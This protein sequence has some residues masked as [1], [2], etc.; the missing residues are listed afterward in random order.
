MRKRFTEEQILAVLA[1][2]GGTQ[3]LFSGLLNTKNPPDSLGGSHC[4]L[5]VSM[6]R[7]HCNVK[8]SVGYIPLRSRRDC[9]LHPVP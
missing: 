6:L 8:S 9:R 7:M 2:G 1:L 3:R 5:S 4:S